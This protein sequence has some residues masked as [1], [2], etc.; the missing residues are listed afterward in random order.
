[1]DWPLLSDSFNRQA[2]LLFICTFF[3]FLYFMGSVLVFTSMSLIF[4]LLYV[5]CSSYIWVCLALYTVKLVIINWTNLSLLKI[6][7]LTKIY[8]LYWWMMYF[9]YWFYVKEFCHLYISKATRIRFSLV[10]WSQL[11]NSHPDACGFFF[12]IAAVF[13]LHTSHFYSFCNNCQ[14]HLTFSIKSIEGVL[15]DFSKLSQSSFLQ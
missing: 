6:R 2:A 3:L 13:L 15:L 4:K 14:I 8:Q 5:F 7:L 9:L 10:V 12:V 11:Q 1:M